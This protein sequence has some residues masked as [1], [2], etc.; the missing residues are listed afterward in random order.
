MSHNDL[1]ETI[2]MLE[3]DQEYL[4]GTLEKRT[5]EHDAKLK[6]WRRSAAEQ[7]RILLERLTQA[8]SEVALQRIH[9][10]ELT[11]ANAF[12]EIALSNEKQGSNSLQDRLQDIEEGLRTADASHAVVAGRLSNLVT[13]YESQMTILKNRITDL[14]KQTETDRLLLAQRDQ[15]LAEST[16]L[17]DVLSSQCAEMEDRITQLQSRVEELVPS[18]ETQRYKTHA[19]FDSG[20][21]TLLAPSPHIILV[22]ACGIRPLHSVFVQTED[23]DALPVPYDITL[24]MRRRISELESA[25]S[26]IRLTKLS[27]DVLELIDASARLQGEVHVL[28][29]RLEGREAEVASITAAGE[30]NLNSSSGETFAMSAQ[31]WRAE[32]L[33][34]L[35]VAKE[36]KSRAEEYQSKLAAAEGKLQDEIK[37]R[38]ASYMDVVQQHAS[39]MGEL[40]DAVR[41]LESISTENA[42]LKSRMDSLHTLQHASHSALSSMEGALFES[43][44]ESNKWKSVASEKDIEVRRLAQETDKL[45]Q[46][47]ARVLRWVSSERQQQQQVNEAAQNNSRSWA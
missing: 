21:L 27:P 30:D 32:A 3:G 40:A 35:K 8:E 31:R 23:M 7:E 9:I 1:V 42:T 6:Q 14:T 39:T 34:A 43:R 37:R 16:Q 46:E 4:I 36:W 28:K 15:A 18:Y 26:S 33:G 13:Q 25:L 41:R 24:G 47:K 29:A 38:D 11:Q 44:G 5:A 22:S 2:D 12:L 17:H 10:D 20:W 19:K 45:K